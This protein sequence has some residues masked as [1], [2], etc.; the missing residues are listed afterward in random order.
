MNYVFLFF[1]TIIIIII[2]II[3]QFKLIK[4]TYLE[5]KLNTQLSYYLNIVIISNTIFILLNRIYLL[6]KKIRKKI[7]YSLINFK[8]LFLCF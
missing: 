4:Y 6:Y 2:I 8:I 7:N 1:L 5:K 3:E